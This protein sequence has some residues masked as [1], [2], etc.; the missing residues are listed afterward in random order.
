MNLS[1]KINRLR[2][3]M[4]AAAEHHQMNLLHPDVL[5]YSQKLD[6]LI[7]QAMAGRKAQ[8]C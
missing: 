2:K 5:S 4:I 8:A 7:V 1:Q 3:Q 6:L